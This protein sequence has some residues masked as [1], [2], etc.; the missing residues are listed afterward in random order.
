MTYRKNGVIKGGKMDELFK[1]ETREQIS[2]QI[3]D[4]IIKENDLSD[5]TKPVA[6][7]YV[8]TIR[9]LFEDRGD[10]EPYKALKGFIGD[11][12]IFD[13]ESGYLDMKLVSVHDVDY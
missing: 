3:S 7:R 4:S 2:K 11:R 6:K 1:K 12:N 10:G 9:C 13:G 5:L 8:A